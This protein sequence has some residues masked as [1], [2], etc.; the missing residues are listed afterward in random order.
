MAE[1]KPDTTGLLAR[2]ARG[3]VALSAHS[4]RGGPTPP[5]YPHE[6]QS[7]LDQLAL[8]C[9]Q[10][11]LNP[12]TGVPELISWCAERTFAQWAEMGIGGTAEPAE[13]LVHPVAKA[14]TRICLEIAGHAETANRLFTTAIAELHPGGAAR[15]RAFLQH[16][17]VVSNAAHRDLL[18]TDPGSVTAFKSVRHL[19]EPAPTRLISDGVIT[20]CPTCGL[21][22]ISA[23]LPERGTTWCE[24]EVCPRDKPVT[25]T[26]QAADVLLLHR[27]LRL[28]LSLPGLVER[29]CLEQ[30][31]AACRPLVQH[32]AT[33]GMYTAHLSGAENVVR[34]YDRT[35]AT[36]LAKQVVEEQV[37]AAVLPAHV[38]SEEFR[39]VFKS[40]LPRNTG[41]SLLSDE[42]LVHE[43]TTKEKTDAKQ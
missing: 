26:R 24:A 28:F 2:I 18:I 10:G 29:S 23:D 27:A 31:Q 41:I 42:E 38:L 43:V 17:V 11:N 6:A 25:D 30:L 14:P 35:C 34:F 32:E 5:P 4:D 16:H 22:A 8:W 9:L 39:R 13:R 7:A 3:V 12:P 20:L 37:T 21:P 36:R 40:S 15:A 1:T 19:Y 33:A